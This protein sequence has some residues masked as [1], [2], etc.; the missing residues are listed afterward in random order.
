MGLSSKKTKT[1]SDS[2]SVSTPI[3]PAEVTN[4]LTG[5]AGTITGLQNQ[6]PYSFTAAADPLQTKAGAVANGL[7]SGIGGAMDTATS[8]LGN[9]TDMTNF[10]MNAK[11][12][13]MTAQTAYGGIGNYMDPYLTDVV[14]T[15]LAG[16]D[17][18]AGSQQAQ[19]ALDLAGDDTFG[20]S[21][22][23]LYK[24]KLASDQ[25]LDRASTEAGLRSTGWNTA[26][27]AAQQDAQR[28][29]DA[30]AMN[31]QLHGQ[32]MDRRLTGAAQLG[33]L[34]TEGL[35]NALNVDANNRSNVSS[36]K[37]MGEVLRQIQLQHNTA[38]LSVAS[39]I[40]GLYGS[41]PFGLLHGQ[42][43]TSHSTSTTKTTD[44]MGTIAG[45]AGAAG[46]VMS[47]LGGLGLGS[48]LLGGAAGGAAG[49][50]TGG[51]GSAI[52]NTPATMSGVQLPSR[53]GAR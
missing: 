12:P 47:G 45:L 33:T 3:N 20:G 34:G 36:M 18:N 10:I 42:D 13:Q 37:D 7:G 51:L 2:H 22:G 38:P 11:A 24:A 6:D 16:F 14:N 27:G 52:M 23:A 40:A 15:T 32:M 39:T 41:T 46:A 4:G 19:A 28:A 31:A 29:Q 35:N 1:T 9:A 44:P 17:R 50:L 43:D 26:L 5:F 49:G 53:Y 21:G 48:G 25:G 8:S 30:S